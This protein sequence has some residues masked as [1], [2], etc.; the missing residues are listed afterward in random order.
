MEKIIQSLR[1]YENI[2]FV[3]WWTGGHISP[4]VSLF[5]LLKNSGK[6]FVWIWWKW[7][8][9]EKE[10]QKNKI[11]FSKI[12]VLKLSTTKSPKI[13]LYPFAL[14]KSILEAKKILLQEKKKNWKIVI[15]SKWGPGALA[16][17]IAGNLLN[18]PVFI[19]ESDTIP[20]RSNRK[21]WK[22]AKKIFLGFDFSKK[23]FD[24]KKCEVV[25]QILDPLLDEENNN[26]KIHWKTKKK[27]ILVLCGSQWAKSVFEEIIKSCKDID[28]EWLV[29]LGKLN[30]D[31]E[32]DFENFKNIQIL[33]WLEK[34]EQREI[35][36]KTNLAITRGSA[37]TLAELEKFWIRKIIIP[38]P[39]AASNHQFFNAVEY[40]GNGDI[41]LEQKNIH[42]LRDEIEKNL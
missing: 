31:M 5:S 27:H 30:S 37:T 26:Q 29:I 3:W 8:E 10:A 22:I 6:N 36:M 17:G 38:L 28:A 12:S 9:E 32:K 15:F 18:I 1:E 24:E 19:H 21:L 14:V 2:I 23:Y 16:I 25:G 11:P 39:N 40:T 7:G 34:V 13:L 33:K 20:G 42:L 4:I 41:L 35:F